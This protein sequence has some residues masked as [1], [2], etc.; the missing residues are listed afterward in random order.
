LNLVIEGRPPRQL[1]QEVYANGYVGAAFGSVVRMADGSYV[2]G[3]LSRGVDAARMT[4]AKQAYDV[5]L[6]R[7]GAQYQSLGPRVWLAETP[8]RHE[9]NL[10]IAPYGPDRLFVSWDNV[11]DVRCDN[12]LTCFG[13][14]D[15]T[16]ARLTD[17]EGNFLTPETRIRAV[18]NTGEDISVFPNLDLGWAYVPDDDRSYSE[19]LQVDRATQLARVEP[20]RRLAVARL[21]YC[22]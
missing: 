7:L 12:G 4:A 15:G 6:L 17:L 22:P 14:Y 11:V 19:P 21:R 13:R 1:G 2:V 18:P 8:N 16:I 3:W 10:H 5:A 9:T 20:K